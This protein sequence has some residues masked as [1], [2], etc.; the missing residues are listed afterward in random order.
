MSEPTH[1]IV[2]AAAVQVTPRHA[3]AGIDPVVAV[4]MQRPDVTAD[5]VRDMLAAQREYRADLARQAFDD[6]FAALSLELPQVIAKDRGVSYGSGKGNAYKYATLSSILLAVKPA[7][8]AHG[9]TTRWRT[10]SEGNTVRVTCELRHRDGHVEETSLAGPPDMKGSKS[11]VQAIGST[12]SYLERY[13]LI[14]SLGITTGD[15]PDADERRPEQQR[16]PASIDA[17]RTADLLT[18]LRKRHVPADEAEQWIGRP[19][20]EWTTGD[21][22]AI[23]AWARG[24][25]R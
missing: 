17:K 1:E 24:S 2:E 19:H 22:T 18:A 15:M 13:T 10:S 25:E 23:W 16:D 11:A 12:T 9:F 6:A 20:A 8:S 14:A 3:T 7:L 4:L 21:L 5:E